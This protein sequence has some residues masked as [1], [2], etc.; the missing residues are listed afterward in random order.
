MQGWVM[1]APHFQNETKI[2]YSLPLKFQ[3]RRYLQFKHIEILMW[4]LAKI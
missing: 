4:M 3:D 2:V 1:W